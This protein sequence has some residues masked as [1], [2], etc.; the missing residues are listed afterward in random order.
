MLSDLYIGAFLGFSS[1]KKKKKMLLQLKKKLVGLGSIAHGIGPKRRTAQ[2]PIRVPSPVCFCA[3]M[4]LA[5]KS[6]TMGE[7]CAVERNFSAGLDPAVNHDL[8]V[9]PHVFSPNRPGSVWNCLI[10]ETVYGNALVSYRY[11]NGDV[12]VC[13]S[14]LFCHHT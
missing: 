4:Y 1:K 5:G 14:F 10:E 7:G 6:S 11:K 2:F 3:R 8:H 9:Q 12:M 13:F